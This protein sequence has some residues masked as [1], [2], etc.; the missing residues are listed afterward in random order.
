MLEEWGITQIDQNIAFIN[1]RKFYSKL[2]ANQVNLLRRKA[3]ETSMKRRKL[4]KI[5]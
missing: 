3:P 1:G 2:T 5:S 4:T